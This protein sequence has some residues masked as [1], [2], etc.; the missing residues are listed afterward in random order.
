MRPMIFAL[1]FMFTLT[2]ARA[3]DALIGTSP[4]GRFAFLKGKESI[5]LVALPS[6]KVLLADLFHRETIGEEPVIVWSKDSSRVAFC[7]WCC[8]FNHCEA[9][10]RRNGSFSKLTLP[11]LRPPVSVDVKSERQKPEQWQDGKLLLV[12]DGYGSGVH[13]SY[14][15]T[16]AFNE[17]GKG[18]VTSVEKKL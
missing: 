16:V 6:R 3:A 11:E 13:Y 7:T 12:T 10:Q 15:Y 9:F 4:D 5:Q 2:W 18:K 14:E 17:R 1:L 8:R